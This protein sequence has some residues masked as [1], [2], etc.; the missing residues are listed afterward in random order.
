MMTTDEARAYVGWIKSALEDA[1]GYLLQLQDREGWRALG[2]DS[3]RACVLAEFAEFSQPRLYQLLDAAKVDR[4]IST[5][6]ETIRLPERHARALAPVLR[7]CGP[8]VVQEVYRYARETAGIEGCTSD[9]L[10]VTIGHLEAAEVIHL[11]RREKHRPVYLS[12]M[13]NTPPLPADVYDV[14]Y[15]DPPWSYEWVRTPNRAIENHYPTMALE[16]ICAL[17][18]ANLA[19]PNALLALWVPHPKSEEGHR[20]MN[21]WG[22]TYRAQQVWVKDR[23]GMGNFVRSRHELLFYGVRGDF[24]A[25]LEANR[26]ASVI[27]APRG[28]HSEKPAIAYELI[29][30]MYPAAR[31]VELFA[32]TARPGWD[33]WGNEAPTAK[34][35]AA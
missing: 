8:S 20:V 30:R 1:R 17:L 16:A 14:I 28:R 11:P 3:W 33:C 19:A 31:R 9:H 25:P 18:I 4:A 35:G 12:V 10:E 32:R 23:I 15:A 7:H 13:A 6:V 29:E 24:P 27:E 2:Y 21:T 5:T 26:P 22:F 34:G